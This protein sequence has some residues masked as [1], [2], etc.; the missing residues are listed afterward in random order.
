MTLRSISYI[1]QNQFGGR[2]FTKPIKCPVWS[3]WQIPFTPSCNFPTIYNRRWV[4]YCSLLIWF[5]YK[6]RFHCF[7]RLVTFVRRFR[8]SKK[9][10]LYSLKVM[11]HATKPYFLCFHVNT[12]Y[13]VSSLMKN[14]LRLQYV[15][16]NIEAK[17]YS[18]FVSAMLRIHLLMQAG[19]KIFLNVNVGLRAIIFYCLHQLL[20]VKWF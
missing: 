14:L 13:F 11:L 8:L 19:L 15:T 17:G 6:D 9:L 18:I 2:S 20:I 16:H 10:H 4:Q 1:F 7:E 3:W 12:S 5:D